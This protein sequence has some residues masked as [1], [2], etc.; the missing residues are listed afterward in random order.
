M[1][2]IDLAMLR[3]L[4]REKEIPFEELA[5]IIEQAIQSEYLRHA[6]KQNISVPDEH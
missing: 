6:E 2:K 5:E 4:E 3:G 1:V